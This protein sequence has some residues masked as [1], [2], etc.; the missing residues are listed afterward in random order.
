M[1]SISQAITDYLNHCKFEKNLSPKT[2]KAYSIDLRQFNAFISDHY[3]KIEL[4]L[5]SKV[6][7]RLYVA[8]IS[9]L[10]PKSIK[11]KIASIKALFNYL[12]FED[13]ILVSPLRK[14]NI[15]IKE[16]RML[17][18]VM[19]ISEI[20]KIYKAAFRY[21]KKLKDESRYSFLEALRN[22]VVLEL[23]FNTGARVSEIADLKPE[24]INV[25]T[26]VIKLKGKG[27][28]ERIIQICNGESLNT[29]QKYFT[30]WRDKITNAGYFLVNRLG[31]K[32]SDQSIRNLIKSLKVEAGIAKRVTP[33]TFR[34]SFATLLLEKDVDIKYIQ[35]MLGHSSIMTTQI[36]THVNS[37][38]QRQILALKHPR[39]EIVTI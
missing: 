19:N 32:L 13:L 30:L 24:Q 28:K 21:K 23:L 39:K 29:I 14:M 22:T 16:P 20:S 37:K 11:R 38:K 6:E 27:D 7:I 18:A 25:L 26:G 34:H 12:E 10:K 9:T 33:H 8:F 17:P 5:I 15:R 35:A 3:P 1:V 2:V 31:N 36:Y 4:E